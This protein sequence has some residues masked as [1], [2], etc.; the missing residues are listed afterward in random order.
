MDWSTRTMCAS[1]DTKSGCL[2]ERGIAYNG[3][4]RKQYQGAGMSRVSLLF[5]AGTA[6]AL[7]AIGTFVLFS[8]IPEQPVRCFDLAASDFNRKLE[9]IDAAPRTPDP[10]ADA[11]SETFIIRF[12]FDLDPAWAGDGQFV[13]TSQRTRRVLYDGPYQPVV[14][15]LVDEEMSEVDEGWDNLEFQLLNPQPRRWCSWFTQPGHQFWEKP[16]TVRIRLMVA[17]WFDSNELLNE[18]EVH[19]P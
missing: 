8:E 19:L 13:I 10:T 14:P 2:S 15:I 5:T 1:P 16:G 6:L 9:E 11:A 12:Q 18:Y 3:R 17:P 7:L 4:A